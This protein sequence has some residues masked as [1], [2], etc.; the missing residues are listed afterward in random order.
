MILYT[1]IPL[2]DIFEGMEEPPIPTIEMVVGGATLELEPLGNFQARVVRIIS[3]DPR[4]YLTSLYQPGS[5]LD[6]NIV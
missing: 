4:H 2:D 5:I 6:L 3:S 1:V